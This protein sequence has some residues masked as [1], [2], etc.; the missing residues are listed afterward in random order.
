MCCP[1]LSLAQW[2]LCLVALS[3]LWASSAGSLH[4]SKQAH[5]VNELDVVTVWPSDGSALWYAER[6][7]GAWQQTVMGLE[8]FSGCQGA[9]FGTR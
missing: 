1:G 8:A 4:K 2:V 3:G 7:R 6:Q 5:L 9:G